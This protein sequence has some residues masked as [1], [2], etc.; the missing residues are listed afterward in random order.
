MNR[1]TNS[2]AIVLPARALF[3]AS[4]P[5]YY[6]YGSCFLCRL[7]ISSAGNLAHTLINRIMINKGQR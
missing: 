2:G 3:N 6:L 7:D 5:V 1:G 4:T